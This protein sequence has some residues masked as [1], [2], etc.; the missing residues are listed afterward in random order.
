MAEH[1]E[2]GKEGEEEACLYLAFHDYHILKRNWRVG[3]LEID[4]VADYF[5]EIVF[6]EVKTRR[7]ENVTSALDAVDDEK[8]HNVLMAARAY[9]AYYNEDRPFRFDI[10]TV[11][12]EKPP[13]EIKQY[14][15]AFGVLGGYH[16]RKKG[17]RG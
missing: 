14:V 12:G 5:G 6:I 11:V 15:N 3:H 4:I 9:I 16:G 8:R 13:Y 17:W 7:H 10:I 2:F 1:N